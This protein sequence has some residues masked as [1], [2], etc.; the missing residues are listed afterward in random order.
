MGSSKRINH[1]DP[2][3]SPNFRA[4]AYLDLNLKIDKNEN[5]NIATKIF[6]D[7]IDGRYVAHVDAIVNHASYVEDKDKGT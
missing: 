6:H 4:S 7:R 1:N 2:K 3:I 5:W